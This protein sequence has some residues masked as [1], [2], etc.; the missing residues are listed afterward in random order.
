MLEN[1]CVLSE[2]KLRHVGK[3]DEGVQEK[4]AIVRFLNN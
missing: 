4:S 2:S 3:E 1:R